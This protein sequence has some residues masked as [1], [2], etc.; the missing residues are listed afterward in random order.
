MTDGSWME[1]YSASEDTGKQVAAKEV[2]ITSAPEDAEPDQTPSNIV[3]KTNKSK[4]A[5]RTVQASKTTGKQVATEEVAIS[6]APE[7][8]EPDQTPSN[9]TRKINK[10]EKP[11]RTV[12]TSK[13]KPGAKAVPITSAPEDTKLD[14]TPSDVTSDAAVHHESIEGTTALGTK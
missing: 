14:C 8:A 11:P 4:K 5:S 13:G 1:L 12:Q 2:A 7:D 3:R 6:S 9:V 10:S